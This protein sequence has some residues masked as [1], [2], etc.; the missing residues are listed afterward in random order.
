MQLRGASNC[1]GHLARARTF[2]RNTEPDSWSVCDR[3]WRRRTLRSTAPE[4]IRRLSRS[5]PRFHCRHWHTASNELNGE[6]RLVDRGDVTLAVRVPRDCV[7][8]EKPATMVHCERAAM[9]KPSEPPHAS[10]SVKSLAF[11]PPRRMLLI[12][13]VDPGPV[14]E[15]GPRSTR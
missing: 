10:D 3:L 8:G 2:A 15:E 1:P 4:G 11:F 5:R 7:P 14:S 9:R 13:T 12:S 6:N